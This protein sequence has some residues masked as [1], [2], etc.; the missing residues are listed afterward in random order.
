MTQR[1]DLRG[2]PAWAA[3]AAGVVGAGAALALGEIASGATSQVPSLVVAVGEA[4]IDYSPTGVTRTGIETA[5]TNDKPALL[6]G[7]VIVTLVIGALTGRLA[8][9]RPRA[10]AAVFG[11]F[12]IV[13]GWA[14]ARNPFASAWAAWITAIV[15]TAA[16]VFVMRVLLAA[17]ALRP[18]RAPSE[19]AA[20]PARLAEPDPAF[21]NRRA[22]LTLSVGAGAV[23]VGASALGRS[24][25]HSRTIDAIRDRIALPSVPTVPA[26]SSTP[27]VAGILDGTVPGLSP[28]FTPDSDF[29]RIDTA[30]E[31][32]QVDPAHWKL[33]VRGFVDQP[34]TVTYEELLAMPLVE[35]TVTLSCVSNEIG[36]KLVGNAR[37]LGVPLTTLLDR[38]GVKPEG[39]QIV[40]YSV[41]DFDAGFPTS[42][43]YDGRTALVAVGM[44][45][46]PL[47]AEHGFPARLVVAGLYGYVSAVKWLREIRLTGDDV[48]GYWI[49]RGWSK[50]GPVKTMSR[51]D[52]PRDRA[53]V[54]AGPVALAG[55]AWAPTK[56][57]A[58]VEVQVDDGP[59]QRC[60]LGGATS[61]ET[62][63]QWVL[64]WD[65]P[66]G[67]HTI[68]VRATDKTG[69]TQS[70]VPKDVAPN[71]AEGWHTIRVSV[72]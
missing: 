42:L 67:S 60:R 65:A 17:A 53:K 62:W 40:G 3:A 19:D 68:R 51:I 4:I 61:D 33:D 8:Q 18:A 21:P 48:E 15:C 58:D 69:F 39:T 36:G 5:G 50:L 20:A 29:Y 57:I 35:K 43:A 46:E 63:V 56:G 64:E 71:G 16:G 66:K 26:P 27:A 30:L 38:A 1:D 55:V 34:L 24:W 14:A 37:W 49:P 23:V 2:P 32:P 28:Y 44:N 45:G 22:F 70:S 6:I 59:W 72:S 11:A 41:D 13:G 7:I 12:G 10:A 25:R 9:R 54:A 31:V 52:V 47:P